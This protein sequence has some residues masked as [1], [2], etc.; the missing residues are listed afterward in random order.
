[1]LFIRFL[2][3][4]FLFFLIQIFR[5]GYLDLLIINLVIFYVLWEIF[6]YCLCI[7][8]LFW[9]YFN[10]LF[11]RLFISRQGLLFILI[12]CFLWEELLNWLVCK[13]NH[14]LNSTRYIL[15]WRWLKRNQ[16]DYIYF[17]GRCFSG[18]L[19]SLRPFFLFKTF[20]LHSE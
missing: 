15:L 4:L 6:D 12:F 7:F 17:S 11:L 9:I 14:L 20:I 13:V 2:F 19:E 5:V 18:F 3:F 8:T 16:M 10:L 1:M